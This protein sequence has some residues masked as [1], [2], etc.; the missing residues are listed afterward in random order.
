M[1]IAEGK[2]IT[3]GATPRHGGI[4]RRVLFELYNSFRLQ[5]KQIRAA[6]ATG[7]DVPHRS[8]SAP[9]Y[10]IVQ[11]VR[12]QFCSVPHPNGGPVLIHAAPD[13][14]DATRTV[15]GHQR[16][17]GILDVFEFALQDRG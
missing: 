3:H 11:L 12:D 14:H 9:S 2:G 10:L 17:A 16:C 13:L 15:H 1:P 4:A 6:R 7:T 5:A 8:Q